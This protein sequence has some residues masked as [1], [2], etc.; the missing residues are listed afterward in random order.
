MSLRMSATMQGETGPQPGRMYPHPTGG[1]QQV[2]TTDGLQ[3]RPGAPLWQIC[4][5]AQ[6]QGM[7]WRGLGEA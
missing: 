1:A 7:A 2:R 6:S 5:Q 3:G 4:R